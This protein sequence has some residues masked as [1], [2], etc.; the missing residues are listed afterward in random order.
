MEASW[1]PKV[2][3]D[4]IETRIATKSA[5]SIVPVTF[6]VL[7]VARTFAH[8]CVSIETCL[9]TVHA[10]AVRL[11]TQ[12]VLALTR[13]QQAA[14]I[15]VIAGVTAKVAVTCVLL[16]GDTETARRAGELTGGAVTTRVAVTLASLLVT[17]IM[18]TVDAAPLFTVVAIVT[19][20]T[21]CT[22]SCSLVTGPI[23]VCATCQG[24]VRS[25]ES[26]GAESYTS[27]RCLH[28]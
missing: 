17:C 5:F 28:T 8:T 6:Q 4:T 13:T 12:A 16:A 19:I 15:A 21:Y 20:L 18:V 9:T 23:A 7:A 14:D 27:S 10:C 1:T 11:F 2:T 24:A 26:R 25:I 3:L 22:S